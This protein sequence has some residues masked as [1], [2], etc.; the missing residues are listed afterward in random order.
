MSKFFVAAA[1]LLALTAGAAPSFAD[2]S[3][4]FRPVRPVTCTARNFNG[5]TFFGADRGIIRAQNKALRACRQNSL[6]R[7]APSCRV[8]R[9]N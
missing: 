4:S 1:A 5:R 2:S 8:V 9:C 3:I 6:P 7:V